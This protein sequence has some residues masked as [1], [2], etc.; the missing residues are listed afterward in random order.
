MRRIDLENGKYTYVFEDSGRQYALRHGESWRDLTGDKFVFC[1]AYRVHELEEEVAQL[2]A[3]LD[4]AED[5]DYL[6]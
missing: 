1:L 4:G 2:K 5:E 3:R 6:S